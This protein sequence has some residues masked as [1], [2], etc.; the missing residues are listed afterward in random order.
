MT[1]YWIIELRRKVKPI[2]PLQNTACLLFFLVP[3]LNLRNIDVWK[4]SHLETN[5]HTECPCE[6]FLE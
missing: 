2:V 6:Y 3:M 5:H 1:V 4:G